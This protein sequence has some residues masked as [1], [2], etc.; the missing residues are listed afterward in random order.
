VISARAQ[1][2][3]ESFEAIRA[4]YQRQ[5]SLH[6]FIQA[7]DIANLVLFLCSPAGHKISGQALSVDGN[8]ES[9]RV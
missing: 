4:A 1:A 3:G 2:R 5:N 9:L 6:T 7:Q 8:T